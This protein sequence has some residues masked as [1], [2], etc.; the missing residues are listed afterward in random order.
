MYIS[1]Y[2]YEPLVRHTFLWVEQDGGHRGELWFSRRWCGYHVNVVG[3]RGARRWNA[4][5]FMAGPVLFH[6]N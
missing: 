5:S 4:L 2:H 3:A 6:N 1:E